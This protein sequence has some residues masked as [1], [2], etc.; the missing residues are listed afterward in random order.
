MAGAGSGGGVLCV[1]GARRGWGGAGGDWCCAVGEGR[2]AL[3]K[4]AALKVLSNYCATLALWH[5]AA[6]AWL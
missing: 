3:G 6:L 4:P 2:G 1:P 5:P